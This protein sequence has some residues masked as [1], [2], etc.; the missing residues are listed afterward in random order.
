[1][2]EHSLPSFTSLPA[3]IME[4][5]AN[6]YSTPAANL[7]G[8]STGVSSE[9]VAASTIA[10][11]TGTK[12]WVRFISV[13]LWLLSGLV[14]LAA[15]A[16]A[17]ISVFNPPKTSAIPFGN[18]EFMILAVVYGLLS[19]I[20]IFPAVKLW[21]YANRIGS[22]GAT[23]STTDLD[24]ALNEQRSFWKYA[25]IMTIIIICSYIA[26]FIGMLYF[27]FSTALKSGAF[28]VK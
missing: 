27:G 1:M 10:Q 16:M 13:I 12:P 22:L 19:F 28:P 15:T 24:S 17:A 26:L 21:K 6:P 3:P 20:Y 5:P 18:G 4:S 7:Y 9:I 8:A 23:R 25:G 14:L 2:Q 11:L